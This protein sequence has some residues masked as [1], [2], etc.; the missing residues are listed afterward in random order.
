MTCRVSSIFALWIVQ[1]QTLRIDEFDFE[2]DVDIT[3]PADPS[4]KLI[5]LSA[6]VKR[7]GC[8]KEHD[9]IELQ[10]PAEP[11]R[12]CRQEAPTP[13]KVER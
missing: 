3:L 2:D 1:K 8:E 13:E 4:L 5:R 11:P 7:R 12:V 6:I 10:V 9:N